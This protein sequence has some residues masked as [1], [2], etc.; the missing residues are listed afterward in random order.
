[1]ESVLDSNQLVFRNFPKVA[2]M[3]IS[4]LR[5]FPKFTEKYLCQSFFFNKVAGLRLA[6]LLKKRLW[7]RCF[8]VNSREISKTTFFAEHLWTTV[9][10]QLFFQKHILNLPKD[11]WWSFLCKNSQQ[12]SAINHM[13]LTHFMSLISFDTPWKHQKTS[14]FLMFSGGIKRDQGHEKG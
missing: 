12:L 1:M 9:S 13:P 5:N 3:K 11:I 2:T 6:T 14:G 4:V 8:P 10:K 7:H